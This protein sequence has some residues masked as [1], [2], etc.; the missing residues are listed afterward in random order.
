MYGA[1]YCAATGLKQ[2]QLRL[3][4]IANNV[5]N[6]NTSGFKAARLDF[7]DAIYTARSLGPIASQGENTNLGHGV[8]PAAANRLYD[9]GNIQDTEQQLDFAIEGDGFLQVEDQAGQ[10]LYTRGGNLYLSGLDVDEERFIVNNKGYY[11]HDINGNRITFPAGAVTVESDE[12]GLLRFGGLEDS[13]EIQLGVFTFSNLNGLE[14]VGGDCFRQGIASGEPMVSD[15][16]TVRQGALESSNVSLSDE[17]TRMIRA[18]RAFSLASR[19]LT[20]ADDME[21]IANNMKR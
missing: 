2:Q 7:K 20:T 21:G 15:N 10:L 1:V 16:Y 6:A 4:V 14:S 8:M 13:P 9:P 18:Q 17:I 12:T 11:V 3:D 5:A 19:A